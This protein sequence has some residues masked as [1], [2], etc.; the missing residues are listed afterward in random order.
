MKAPY[1]IFTV[2]EMKQNLK[3]AN[4]FFERFDPITQSPLYTL[5]DLGKLNNISP[6]LLTT[7][8]LKFEKESNQEHEYDTEDFD[9]FTINELLTY[10]EITHRF[11]KNERMQRIERIIFNL[12]KEVGGANPFTDLLY[13]SYIEFRQFLYQHLQQ[14]EEVL[15]PYTKSLLAYSTGVLKEVYPFLKSKLP[16]CFVHSHTKE[17]EFNLFRIFTLVPAQFYDMD[18]T[19]SLMKLEMELQSFKIDLDVHAWIE[20]EV[21]IPK[22]IALRKELFNQ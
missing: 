18:T 20:E 19:E 12:E 16:E 3:T 11:Y 10:V 2:F 9:H 14:E 4:N 6:A 8:L 15:F 5:S 21:C 1:N 22:I 17:T 13:Q 7:I